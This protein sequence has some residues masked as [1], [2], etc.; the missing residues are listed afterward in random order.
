[1]YFPSSSFKRFLELQSSGRKDEIRL[2]YIY[3]GAVHI[4]V[5]PFRLADQEWH[6]VFKYGVQC[7][8]G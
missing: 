7:K 4:E 2:H 5:F 1:M 6:K 8:D 3:E